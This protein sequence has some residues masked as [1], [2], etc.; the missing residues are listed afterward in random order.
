MVAGLNAGRR[1]RGEVEPRVLGR[2]QALT[3]V[4]IDDL[5]REGAQEP[6][7]MFTARSEYRLSV[8]ADNADMRLTGRAIEMGV[9]GEE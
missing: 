2:E 6:Y 7:R 4:L 3:G 9:V 5:I 8:R 1:A